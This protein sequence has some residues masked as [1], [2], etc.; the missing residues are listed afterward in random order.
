MIIMVIIYGLPYCS[1][2]AD[3]DIHQKKHLQDVA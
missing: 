2:Q 1:L 3:T